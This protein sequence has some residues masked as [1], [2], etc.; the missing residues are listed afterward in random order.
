MKTQEMYYQPLPPHWADHVRDA[1]YSVNWPMPNKMDFAGLVAVGA[2][3]VAVAL[4][5]IF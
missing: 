5:I 1:Y 2:I 3:I 4:A